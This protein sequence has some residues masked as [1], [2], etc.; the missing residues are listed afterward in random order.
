[1]KNNFI[2]FVGALALVFAFTLPLF[3]NAGGLITDGANTDETQN[4][5]GNLTDENLTTE[6]T[7]DETEQAVYVL[8]SAIMAGHDASV[9]SRTGVDLQDG[10][11]NEDESDL[12]K[13][14]NEPI[15]D[16]M[17]GGCTA[18]PLSWLAAIF[19]LFIVR[20]RRKRA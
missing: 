11:S 4:T 15:Y 10:D 18:L 9:E 1:M 7:L 20:F 14:I 17:A 16:D 13:L 2:K 8:F 19:A 3:A 5:E 6:N 12:Y